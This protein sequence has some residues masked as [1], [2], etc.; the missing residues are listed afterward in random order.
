[1][2]LI[3]RLN[4]VTQFHHYLRCQLETEVLA[5]GANMEKYIARSGDRVTR[6][7][8]DFTERVKFG[9]PRWSKQR[10][11]YVGSES[12]NAGKVSGGF[13]KAHSSQQLGQITA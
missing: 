4:R 10:I 7:C 13:A 3:H 2:N 8:D 9:R 5:F 1:M 6:P 11:P 12:D